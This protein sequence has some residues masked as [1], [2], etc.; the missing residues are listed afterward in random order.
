MVSITETYN[1][2]FVLNTNSYNRYL[3]SLI[4]KH[5][6]T[7]PLLAFRGQPGN[8]NA[9]ICSIITA[10]SRYLILF[11]TIIYKTVWGWEWKQEVLKS[12]QTERSEMTDITPPLRPRIHHHSQLL[13]WIMPS[14]SELCQNC[15]DINRTSLMAQ[16]WR[17]CLQCK[18]QRLRKSLGWENPLEKEMAISSSI[19][20][21]EISWTEKPS[22]LVHGVAKESDMT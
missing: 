7:F 14:F 11:W 22:G 18:K 19:L 12:L 9:F 3:I 16:W 6:P 13:C 4:R 8:I 15:T 21:W 5:F 17:I 10:G 20:A 2:I 1:W